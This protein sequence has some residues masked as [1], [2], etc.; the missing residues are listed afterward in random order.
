MEKNLNIDEFKGQ[1][2]LPNF[3]TPKQ[4]ELHLTPNFSTCKFSG[5]VQINLSIN[6]KTKFLVLNS[7]ELAIQNTCFT[8]SYGKVTFFQALFEF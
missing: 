2:R 5:K 8:N 1:T 6:E 3:A 4:Y 7:L